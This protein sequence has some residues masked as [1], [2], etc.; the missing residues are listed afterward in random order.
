M[1][2]LFFDIDSQLDFL[3][4]AEAL[5]VRA[6]IARTRKSRMDPIDSDVPNRSKRSAFQSGAWNGNP[7]SFS[8]MINRRSALGS[9][10]RKPTWTT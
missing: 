7:P 10:V 2:P 3:Y 4:P 9:V 6:V 1:K 8:E 5:Y